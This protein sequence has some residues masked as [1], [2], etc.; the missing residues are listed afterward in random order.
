M[1]RENFTVRKWLMTLPSSSVAEVICRRLIDWWYLLKL[2]WGLIIPGL[3]PVWIWLSN[4]GS[5]S[6]TNKHIFALLVPHT[7]FRFNSFFSFLF[8]LLFSMFIFISVWC[9]YVWRPRALVVRRLSKSTYLIWF[10]LIW[11]DLIYTIALPC[12][13]LL[14]LRCTHILDIQLLQT[15]LHSIAVQ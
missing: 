8:L 1:C 7:L 12:L 9:H 15:A 2:H 10:N 11:F 6:V 3:E 4:F 13:Q 14:E 5:D